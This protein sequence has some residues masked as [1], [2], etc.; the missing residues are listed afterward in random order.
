MGNGEEQAL[1]EGR[2]LG[3]ETEMMQ[4]TSA[5]RF[6]FFLPSLPSSLPASCVSVARSMTADRRNV[7]AGSLLPSTLF[8]FPRRVCQ[9]FACCLEM[10]KTSRMVWLGEN[11]DALWEY[12]EYRLIREKAKG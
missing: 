10:W 8:L 5:V 9:F 12:G 11:K 1:D 6:I 2:E 4:H 3:Q 7:L